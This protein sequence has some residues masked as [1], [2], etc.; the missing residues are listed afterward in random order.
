MVEVDP[1]VLILG[2]TAIIGATVV[3]VACS[4]RN[5]HAPAKAS[6]IKK[7][8]PAKS[9]SAKAPAKRETET[10]PKEEL[11][12][13]KQTPAVKKELPPTDVPQP[14]KEQAI[15]PEVS[16]AK[17]TPAP[18]AVSV[19]EVKSV[20]VE[21]E[22]KVSKK[23]KE[24]PEQ[25]AARLERQKLAKANKATEEVVRDLNPEPAVAASV[26]Q[27]SF[28]SGEQE[29]AVEGWEV[30]GK[31]KQKKLKSE[32]VEKKA[33]KK[34]NDEIPVSIDSVRESV[35]VE[36]KKVG[37]IIGP[38]GSTLHKIQDVTGTELTLPK[39]RETALI[40]ITITGPAEGV[41][42]GDAR[43]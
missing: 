12:P 41:K 6:P 29:A 33:E 23:P 1:A 14:P 37:A 7:K 42:K 22:L 10:Q 16:V 4:G 15:T 20:V 21:E 18:A 31:V 36:G 8:K 13:F 26:E 25:K 24:T 27:S 5:T 17:P 19:P 43:N 11:L 38:K 35:V 34:V 39:D 2:G 32:E 28:V 30:V 3:A 40:A 9:A